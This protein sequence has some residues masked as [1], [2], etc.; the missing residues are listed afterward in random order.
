MS[1]DYEP[2]PWGGR[3]SKDRLER[4][5]TRGVSPSSTTRQAHPNHP[6]NAPGFVSSPPIPWTGQELSVRM[7]AAQG[8]GGM[9]LPRFRGQLS[10]SAV[11]TNFRTHNPPSDRPSLPG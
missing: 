3:F 11:A 2:C 9:E 8:R 6:A 5:R 10:T 7:A 4:S 1:V